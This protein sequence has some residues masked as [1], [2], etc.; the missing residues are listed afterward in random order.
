M[1]E[2][3]ALEGL[4]GE[5]Q[6][7]QLGWPNPTW[8]YTLGVNWIGSSFAKEYLRA[9]FGQAAQKTAVCLARKAAN[10]I[11]GYISKCTASRQRKVLILLYSTLA[12]THLEH[13]PVLGPIEQARH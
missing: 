4:K 9:P 2:Q 5:V 13:C 10:H 11:L 7:L 3:K 12:G 6:C 8:L 1:H